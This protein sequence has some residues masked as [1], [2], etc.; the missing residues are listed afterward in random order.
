MVARVRSA[1]VEEWIE[2]AVFV[3]SAIIM[4]CTSYLTY[5]PTS[6][7]TPVAVFRFS[8]VTVVEACLSR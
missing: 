5:S 3:E 2:V 4:A 6:M 7:S 1:T 8:A